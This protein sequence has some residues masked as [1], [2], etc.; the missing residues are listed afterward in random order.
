MSEHELARGL[1]SI[2]ALAALAA[3]GYGTLTLIL[4]I[5]GGLISG[6]WRWDTLIAAAA[7]TAV[8]A[9]H[10][11]LRHWQRRARTAEQQLH[12]HHITVTDLDAATRAASRRAELD[13]LL[14]PELRR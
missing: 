11:N 8:G 13:H 10:V 4:Q 2:A 12:A 5:V 7:L 6:D 14:R 3:I 1:A 9:L